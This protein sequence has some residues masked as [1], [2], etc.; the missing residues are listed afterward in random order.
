MQVLL[1]NDL[2]GGI[3]ELEK[4]ASIHDIFSEFNKLKQ[5]KILRLS[6]P[7]LKIDFS[8][9]LAEFLKNLGLRVLFY[10]G[11]NPNLSGIDSSFPLH[12]DR[13]EQLVSLEIDETGETQVSET[14]ES[15]W[16]AAE[17]VVNHPFLFYIRDQV[18]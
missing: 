10:S 4:Q 1:P 18:T 16:N 3:Q 13:V 17:F 2:Y 15:P 6:L 5:W 11:L 12:L 14:F 9:S 8:L 7:K